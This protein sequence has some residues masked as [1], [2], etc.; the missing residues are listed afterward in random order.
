[1]T[2]DAFSRCHPAVNFLFFVAAIGCGM[3]IQHPAYILAGVVCG[4]VY[5]CLLSGRR[6]FAR[7][8]MLLPLPILTAVLNPLINHRGKAVL[9]LVMG[10][11]YTL[12]ALCYGLALGGIFLVMMLWFGCYSAVL[13]SDKFTSLFGSLIP[14]LSLLLVMVLRLIPAFTRKTKQVLDARRAIGMGA[15]QTGSIPE[16]LRSGMTV[17]SALTSWA[18]EGSII[19]ADSMRSRGYGCG[20]RTSFRLYRMT[21][22][23]WVLL[24]LIGALSCIVLL[25]G[26]TDASYTPVMKVAPLGWGFPAYCALLLIPTIF[27]GKE[28]AAWRIS[29][30]KI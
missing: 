22:R 2:H 30:S 20:K 21:G 19:T 1:M 13:T 11:P 17:L 3:V 24:T 6:G 14:S 29:V 10:K 4:G 28:A 23:D 8:G 5:F 9:F 26:G 7:I 15:E 18:L 12:E 27:E 25:A 16:K